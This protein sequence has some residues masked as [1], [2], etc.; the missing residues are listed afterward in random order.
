MVQIKELADEFV[1]DPVKEFPVGKLVEARVLSVQQATNA[2]KLSLKMSAIQGDVKAL[3]ELSNLNVAD[4]V[5]GKVERITDF[6]VFVAINGT[7]LVGLSRRAA[8]VSGDTEMSSV[9]EAGDVVRAKILSVSKTTRKI[10]LGLKPSFFRDEEED[11]EDEGNGDAMESQSVSDEED[12]EVEIGFDGGDDEDDD[13]DNEISAMIRDAAVKVV[14]DDEENNGED[15]E[16]EEE[17]EEVP[18]KASKKSTVSKTSKMEIIDEV[19][20]NF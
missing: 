2:I 17:E 10:G 7:S 9:Y 1:A 4:V 15:S 5:T 11:E 3:T 14:S 12:D 16:N 8:A 13:S 18:A 6:G 19:T 20:A